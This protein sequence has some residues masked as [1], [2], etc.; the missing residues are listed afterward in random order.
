MIVSE[1]RKESSDEVVAG[2]CLAVT[3]IYTYLLHVLGVF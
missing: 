1:K 2:I 3:V